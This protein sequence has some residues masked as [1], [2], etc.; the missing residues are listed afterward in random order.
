MEGL[1]EINSKIHFTERP[2]IEAYIG[3]NDVDVEQFFAKLNNFSQ[4]TLK[5]HHIRGALTALI[6]MN[7]YWDGQGNFLNDQLFVVADIT[8]KDG[9]LIGLSMLESFSTYIK[10]R[11]LRHI[12]FAELK[13][14]FKIQ[15]RVFIMPAMFI[16]S[17]ALNLLIGG[18]HD[19]DQ[20]IDYKMKINVSQVIAQ[21]FKKHNPE[22]RPIKAKKQG[23]FNLYGR[24]YG[25]LDVEDGYEFKKGKKN[26]K[27]FLENDLSQQI[28]LNNTLKQE[29]RKSM[30]ITG[31]DARLAQQ[32]DNMIQELREPD[33]WQDFSDDDTEDADPLNEW[34][35]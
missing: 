13:N 4:E 27:P 28:A 9:E 20:N 17:N 21:R 26:V 12:K 31:Y 23:L 19:F 32:L 11:D 1:F 29:F 18:T 34:G 3:C 33:E 22:L 30:E 15:N 14:Q 16:Q 6:K 24:L 8:L 35:D 5:D 25:N 10:I 2:F 7:A